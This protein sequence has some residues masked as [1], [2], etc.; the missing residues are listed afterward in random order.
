MPINTGFICSSGSS[1]VCISLLKQ[2][3]KLKR[4][5]VDLLLLLYIAHTLGYFRDDVSGTLLEGYGLGSDEG[6]LS[7]VRGVYTSLGGSV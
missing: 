6:M 7:E 4:H 5:T 2:A 1:S 3:L